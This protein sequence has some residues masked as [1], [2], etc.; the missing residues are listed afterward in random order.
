MKIEIKKTV[1]LPEGVTAAIENSLVTI[2]G[3]SGELQRD[4]FFPGVELSLD[5]N[6]VIISY[7]NA[8]RR[9]KAIVGA[10]EA[11]IKNMARGVTEGYTYKLK[12]VYSHFPM[13]IKQNGN[14]LEVH[15]FLGEKAPRKTKV[16]GAA[17]VTIKKDDITVEG[18]DKEEVGLTAANL[19]QITR[20]KKRD[21]RVFQD[22]IYRVEK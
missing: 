2:K 5:G 16:V 12:V 9:E 10:Y 15:N 18:I 11:H 1:E 3:P 20:V 19:E 14:V 8:T 22:G 21:S 17:K 7:K 6:K 4:L 13:T